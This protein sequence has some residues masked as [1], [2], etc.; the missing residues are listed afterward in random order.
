MI[1]AWCCCT[2]MSL[3][4]LGDA[5]S[6]LIE[7]PALDGSTVRFHDRIIGSGQKKDCYLSD[8][9]E[10][11]VLWYREALCEI[12]LARL[13]EIVGRYREQLFSGPAAQYWSALMCWPQR[14]VRYQ[15]RIGVTAP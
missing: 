2:S 3:V 9:G 8:D 15:E 5:M 14:I 13:Q 10:Y 4:W 6:E 11:V 1:A 7:L 12:E